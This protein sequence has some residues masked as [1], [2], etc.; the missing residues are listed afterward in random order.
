LALAKA[1]MAA[2]WRLSLSLS[3]PTFDADDVRRS[4]DRGVR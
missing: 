3:V 2:R 1:V 4:T